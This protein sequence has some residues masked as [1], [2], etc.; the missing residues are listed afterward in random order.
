[1]L[2]GFGG[3]AGRFTLWEFGIVVIDGKVTGKYN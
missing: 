3:S 1:V 2:F